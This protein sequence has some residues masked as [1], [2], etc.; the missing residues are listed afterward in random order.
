[1]RKPLPEF[2]AGEFYHVY[3]QGNNRDATF[4]DEKDYREFVLRLRHY[5]DEYLEVFSYCLMGNHYH[6]VVRVRDRQLVYEAALRDDMDGPKMSVHAIVCERLRRFVLS[7]VAYVNRRHARK[8]SLFS[9]KP[10]RKLVDEIDYLKHL[11]Y[12]VNANPEL[13]GFTDDFTSYPFSSWAE[14]DCGYGAWIP[15]ETVYEWYDGRAGLLRYVAE[16]RKGSDPS[17]GPT[18]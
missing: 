13:H 18:P 2:V 5:L 10:Q 17:R 16:Q 4:L 1:M 14:L 3:N 7:Y 12:Y 8:G 11:V 6:L 9:P 15:V